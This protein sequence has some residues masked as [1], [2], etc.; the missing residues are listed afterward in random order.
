[1][2]EAQDKLTGL[3]GDKAEILAELDRATGEDIG[4]WKQQ[5]ED[6]QKLIDTELDRRGQRV[7]QQIR[8]RPR[9]A[10]ESTQATTEES[11]PTNDD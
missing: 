6:V 11:Q 2:A 8:N 10:D 1:M 3:L 4:Y 9:P 5:A 7:Q